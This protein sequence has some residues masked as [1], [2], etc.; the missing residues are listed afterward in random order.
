M[1]E[2]RD[3]NVSL[4]ELQEEFLQHVERGGRKITLLALIAT[5]AGAYFAINYFLQLVVFPFGLGIKTQ[6]VNLLD[7]ALMAAGAVSLIISLTWAMA[8]LRDLLFAR[9]LARRVKE[10]RSLQAEAAKKY[11]LES[12]ASV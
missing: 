2:D 7:P 4:I 5:L 6:T 12:N 9:R 3:P 10:I 1:T 11:G 8:G